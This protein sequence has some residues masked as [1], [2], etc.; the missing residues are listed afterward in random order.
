[1]GHS[2]HWHG[3][4]NTSSQPVL[5]FNQICVHLQP[6]R[7]ARAIV[8]HLTL[9]DKIAPKRTIILHQT[10]D[11][12]TPQRTIALH[13]TILNQICVYLQTDRIARAIVLHF[14]TTDK[15]APRR[16]IIL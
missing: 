13:F 5:F 4:R 7:I 8:L 12:I 16:A 6:D 1:M 10:P 3:L 14:I 15:I 9:T 2:L 11:R